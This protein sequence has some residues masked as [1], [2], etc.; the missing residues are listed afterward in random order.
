MSTLSGGGKANE[1]TFQND[2]IRQRSGVRSCVLP[3]RTK[4]DLPLGGRRYD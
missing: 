4:Q 2:M 3:K 1:F